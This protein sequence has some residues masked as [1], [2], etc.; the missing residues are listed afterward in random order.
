MFL[1]RTSIVLAVMLLATVAYLHYDHGVAIMNRERILQENNPIAEH[2]MIVTASLPI[3]N[4]RLLISSAFFRAALEQTLKDYVNREHK[5]FDRSNNTYGLESLSY[6]SF[7]LDLAPKKDSNNSDCELLGTYW[8]GLEDITCYVE[9]KTKCRGPREACK[10][11]FNDRLIDNNIEQKSN[12]TKSQKSSCDL[13]DLLREK[14]TLSSK[15]TYIVD[16]DTEINR[17]SFDFEPFNETLSNTTDITAEH[18]NIRS[19]E[20]SCL[21]QCQLDQK[22]TLLN[23]YSDFGEIFFYDGNHECD[24]K[25][26]NCNQDDF[27]TSIWLSKYCQ[28]MIFCLLYDH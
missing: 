17:F 1:K 18:N 4:F 21:G 5:C 2:E 16:D 7:E 6:T 20:T 25:G 26:I 14:S 23:I 3:D 24:H 12:K 8:G 28:S 27:V 19:N 22:E 15:F 11:E 13:D 10:K 9:I